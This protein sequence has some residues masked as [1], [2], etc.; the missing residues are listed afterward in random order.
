M[1]T[2]TRPLLQFIRQTSAKIHFKRGI[3]FDP[4]FEK[5]L[6]KEKHIHVM[7]GILTDN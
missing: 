2:R 1:M 6:V 3:I 4:L 5:R 7:G